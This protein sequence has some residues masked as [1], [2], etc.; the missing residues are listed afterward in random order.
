MAK[1]PA[2]KLFVVPSEIGDLAGAVGTLAA[3]AGLANEDAAKESR[4][5]TNPNG[6]LNGEP[7]RPSV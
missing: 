3:G 5:L 7:S 1:G 6:G 4:T 2:S